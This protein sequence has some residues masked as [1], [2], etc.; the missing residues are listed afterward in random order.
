MR[1]PIRD[2]I[3]KQGKYGKT[4]DAVPGAYY[5]VSG[6]AV[7]NVINDKA[8]VLLNDLFRGVPMFYMIICLI[9]CDV[10]SG[11]LYYITKRTEI[12]IF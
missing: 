11:Y 5:D 6:T 8:H 9:F 10:F 3:S 12:S 4:F 1:L 7:I 2:F